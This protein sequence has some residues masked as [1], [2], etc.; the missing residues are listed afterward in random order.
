[1]AVHGHLTTVVH[2]FEKEGSDVPYT[3]AVFEWNIVRRRKDRRFRELTIEVSF[4]AHGK[5]G[6]TEAQA[7][8]RRKNGPK[9]LFWDPEVVAMAPSGTEWYHHTSH[10]V[11]D[12]RVPE[13]SVTGSLEFPAL[14]FGRPEARAGPE[15]GCA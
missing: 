12:T 2:G 8:R 9:E 11:E 14:C 5:R 10:T 1:M 6:A 4:Q 7:A 3:L 15:R 13:I